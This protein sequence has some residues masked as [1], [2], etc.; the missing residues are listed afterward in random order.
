MPIVDCRRG[1]RERSRVLP[2]HFDARR[3]KHRDS[4]LTEP[5]DRKPIHCLG[6]DFVE[7][8][9][10]N[11]VR[12]RPTLLHRPRPRLDELHLDGPSSSHQRALCGWERP[13]ERI[14]LTSRT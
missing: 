12:K 11:G 2:D 7:V 4:S 3:Q 9:A 13:E 1:V 8:A 6:E 5:E 10:W 14:V